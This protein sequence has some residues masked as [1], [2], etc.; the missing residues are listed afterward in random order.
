MPDAMRCDSCNGNVTGERVVCCGCHEQIVADASALPKEVE[1]AAEALR[2]SVKRQGA[3][4]LEKAWALL[5]SL[6]GRANG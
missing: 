5:D 1:A 3:D 2:A 6:E 4:W